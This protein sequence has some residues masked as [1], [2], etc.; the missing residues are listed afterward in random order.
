MAHRAGLGVDI[1]LDRVL[2]REDGSSPGNWSCPKARTHDPRA[3]CRRE[4]ELAELLGHFGLDVA[5]IGVVASH[6]RYR[7]HWHGELVCD[8]DVSLL[9]EAPLQT[10]EGVES[11]E[12]RALREQDLSGL[13]QVNDFGGVLLQLLSRPTIASKRAVFERFDQ[14]VMTN[15]VVLPGEADAAVM[16]IRGTELGVAAVI[17]CN[18]RYVQ[19]DPF[20]GAAGAVAE[21]ARNLACV[22]ATPL[23]LT[24]NLNFGDPYR[25]EV[26]WQLEQAIAGISAAASA[27]DTPVTGG[28]VS[29]Y[30]QYQSEGATVAIQPT[31]T[32]GMVGVPPDGPGAPPSPSRTKTA[33]FT[34]SGSRAD[35]GRQ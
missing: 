18:P 14:Q 13:P 22:G 35:S 8:L 25:P 11:Q 20:E 27:L 16:R 9:N 23:A 5:E 29:L 4:Q 21:A 28:N 3:G 33:A 31:P 12:I 24:D 32:I 10:R 19:L 17:D 26:Y 2:V 6:G 15:T 1:Q 30:T 34:C 7:L